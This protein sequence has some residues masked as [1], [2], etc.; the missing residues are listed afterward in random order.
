[1]GKRRL[2]KALADYKD[3]IQADIR[4]RPFQLNDSLPKGKGLNKME[5]YKEKFGEERIQ[6]MIPY[7]QSIGDECG[8]K[9]SYGG[10]IGNTFDSHRFIWKARDSDGGELQNK[11]VDAL[12]AAYFENEQSLS[13]PAVLRACA[14]T[15]G[16]DSGITESLLNDETIGK[17]AVRREL[18]EFRS[19][20]NCSG[21]PLFIVNGQYPLS[22]AQ[23]PEA[24]CEIFDTV[25]NNK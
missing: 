15:A 6:S 24:F 5:M 3:T 17:D 4:W 10:N 12:F 9:F 19:K 8:I 16:L 22:G 7:M 25:L 13:D 2:D 20:W 23:P 14:S 21:V 1:M 18:I 11:L